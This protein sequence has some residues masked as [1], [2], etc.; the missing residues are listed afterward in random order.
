M[1]FIIILKI[2][3]YGEVWYR[4]WFGSKRPRVRIPI[5]R[6]NRK[7]HPKGGLFYLDGHW[8]SK[9]RPEQSEGKKQSGG[10]FL[11]SWEN[12]YPFEHI[13][14]WVGIRLSYSQSG[15]QPQIELYKTGIDKGC[16]GSSFFFIS[17]PESVSIMTVPSRNYPEIVNDFLSEIPCFPYTVIL[18][19]NG[20]RM[21]Y[22]ITL[23]V[24]KSWKKWDFQY[25]CP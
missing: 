17:I 2:S 22:N 11:R 4:A 21:M 5:L 12:P 8:D 20:Y 1:F 23:E 3:G 15:I 7:A 10:L 18:F 19:R 24:R 25:I 13:L 14:S 6:P 9:Y 16:F